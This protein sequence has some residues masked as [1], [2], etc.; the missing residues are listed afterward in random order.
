MKNSLRD[1]CLLGLCVL[2]GL[3]GYCTSVSETGGMKRVIG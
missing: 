2:V 1:F 3:I